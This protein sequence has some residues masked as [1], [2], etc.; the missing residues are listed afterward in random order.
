MESRHE[1][2]AIQQMKRSMWTSIVAIVGS[3]L[4]LLALFSFQIR[5]FV[6]LVG[7]RAQASLKIQELTE[8]K[9]R[10]IDMETGIRGYSISKNA[11]FLEP[12]SVGSKAYPVLMAKLQDRFIHEEPRLDQIETEID[13]WILQ[14]EGFTRLDPVREREQIVQREVDGKKQMDSIRASIDSLVSEIEK[15]REART[16][17]IVRSAELSLA[18]GF[19]VVSILLLLLIWSVRAQIR[20]LFDSYN[21]ALGS[22]EA[23]H[24]ELLSLNSHLEERVEERTVALRV[25]NDELESFCYS[26]SHDL[27]AP[28]RGIDGFSLALV[29]DY[30]DKIDESG[31]EY[32]S[33]IRQGVQRMGSLIDDLL[34]LSR[35]SRAELRQGEFKV[36]TLVQDVID[37]MIRSGGAKN[38]LFTVHIAEDLRAMGDPG[39]IRIMMENL[40]SNA[41]KYSAEG[42]MPTVEISC[43]EKGGVV[44]FKIKDNGVGFDMIYADKLFQPFQRLH[45]D[46]RFIGSGIGLATVKRI[47]GRHGG[48]IWAMSKPGEGAEFYFVISGTGG[49]NAKEQSDSVGR[50]QQ[51]GRTADHP[52][53]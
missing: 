25:I 24:R 27:R 33:F 10:V 15:I 5:S 23:A 7:E 42:E 16:A 28:L 40:L 50:G 13:A 11:V 9:A 53:P 38:T 21:E 47:V 51:A 17:Q 48:D 14:Q 44:E 45:S 2:L 20:K 52:R 36:R 22:V 3:M 34:Q 26:V 19:A 32:L 6:T 46:P 39:L 30:S 18:L 43:V 31:R 12:F 8:L 29:E 41:V 4:L 1:K 37:D 35:I 49:T